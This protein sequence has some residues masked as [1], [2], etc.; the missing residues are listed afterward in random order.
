MKTLL[1]ALPFVMS[2]AIT[3][4]ALAMPI[5]PETKAVVTFIFVPGNDG[6]PVANG[7][8]FFV[9][10]KDKETPDKYSVY[11]VTA[12]HV[13]QKEDTKTFFPF[14]FVRI[15][16]KD[17]GAEMLRLNLLTEG[18]GKNVFFHNDPS[19][20]IAIVP[21]LPDQ[22]KYDFKF[23]PDDFLTTK[24]EFKKLNI[25]EGSDVFFTGLFAHQFAQEVADQRN[26]PI[27]RFGKVALV[28]DEKINWGK[29]KDPTE[30]YLIESASYGGN[31][32]SPVYFYLGAEREPGSIMVGAPILKLAG[33]MLGTFTETNPITVIE[34]GTV[35]V[36]KSSIGIALVVPAYKLYEILFSDEL[37]KHRKF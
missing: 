28:I 14:V 30:L 10:V 5:P 29:L 25:R 31:S 17:S 18:I 13:F 20:D 1:I 36:S 8:G 37:K 2:I 22:Q 24:D 3:T 27:V 15:N 26:H 19:V 9:G 16:K 7:T 33:V 4:C 11:L 32:G 21:A 34:T 6:K 23:L 12:K 35:P